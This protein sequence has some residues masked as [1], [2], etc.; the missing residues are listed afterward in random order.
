MTNEDKVQVMWVAM[1]M[2]VIAGW[3]LGAYMLYKEFF[4]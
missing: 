2:F 3:V 1:W 4:K